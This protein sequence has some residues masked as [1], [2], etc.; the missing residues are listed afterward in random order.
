[1]T[2][3]NNQQILGRTNTN[4]KRPGFH[5]QTQQTNDPFASLSLMDNAKQLS[6]SVANVPVVKPKKT[7]NSMSK[8]GKS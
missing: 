7:L 8:D 3:P 6:I 5:R 4:Q 1:M 2:I